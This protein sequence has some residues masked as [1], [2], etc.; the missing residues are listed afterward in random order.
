MVAIEEQETIFTS[1]PV[2]KLD[3]PASAS[4]GVDA[5]AGVSSLYIGPV[6]GIGLQP[7]GE[8]VPL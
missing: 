6:S 5:L 2:D 3:A 8:T 7:V 4:C 1:P